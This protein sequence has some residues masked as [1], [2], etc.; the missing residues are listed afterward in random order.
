MKRIF[1]I[2]ISIC[3][4]LCAC[5]NQPVD[6]TPTTEATTEATTPHTTQATTEAT[7]EVTTEPTTVPTTEALL[8]QHPLNGEL[9]A[10]PWVGRATAIVINN[11]KVCLPQ[12]GIGPADIVY[13]YETE[14]GI[15]RLLAI[16]SNLE[17][18]GSIGP[19]RSSRTF[20][21]STAL[22]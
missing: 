20:F 11:I 1:L 14:G 9:L 15:T 2:L 19:V 13:E 4:I 8:Y 22:A 17:D 10:Q 3:L 7:T 12:H 18:V 5:S 21:N 6:T 16:Y